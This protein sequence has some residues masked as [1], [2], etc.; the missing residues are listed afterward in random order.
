MDKVTFTAIRLALFYG[1]L[2]EREIASID[3]VKEEIKEKM[4]ENGVPE[5]DFNDILTLT[6]EFKS[7]G[8]HIRAAERK[9]LHITK[10]HGEK[11][12]E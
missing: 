12:P 4:R 2:L 6:Y 3:E 10:F 11:L 1:G 8:D 9:K 5:D 7:F